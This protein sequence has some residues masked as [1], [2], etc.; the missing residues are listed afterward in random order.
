MKALYYRNPQA[1]KANVKACYWKNPATKRALNPR[2]KK[3]RNKAYYSKNALR[4]FQPNFI[5][6]KP[7]SNYN[8]TFSTYQPF[9]HIFQVNMAAA[10][11]EES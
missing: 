3:M 11:L 6:T 2:A 7:S 5:F 4:Y 9:F 1:K 10:K 8:Y